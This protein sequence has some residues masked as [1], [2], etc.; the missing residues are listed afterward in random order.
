MGMTDED[1]KELLT[2]SDMLHSL[3]TMKQLGLKLNSPVMLG[4]FPNIG[5]GEDV[6]D[7][8]ITFLMEVKSE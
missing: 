1:K 3:V 7:E 6:L 5:N 4:V 2:V 8:A